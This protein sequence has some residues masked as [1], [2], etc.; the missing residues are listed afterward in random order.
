VKLLT[1]YVPDERWAP[2]VSSLRQA[3]SETISVS[4]Q[5]GA[6]S[7]SEALLF[8]LVRASGRRPAQVVKI[9]ALCRDDEAERLV[10]AI[11]AEEASSHNDA[12]VLVTPWAAASDHLTRTQPTIDDRKENPE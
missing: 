2:V 1:A 10:A 5:R 6:V 11:G 12:I 7:E 3:G 8:A 9:Q 4:N